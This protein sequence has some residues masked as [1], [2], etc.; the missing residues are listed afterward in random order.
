MGET[1]VISAL[2]SSIESTTVVLERSAVNYCLQQVEIIL[3]KETFYKEKA[4]YI[5]VLTLN[6][7]KRR[8]KWPSFQR[9]KNLYCSLSGN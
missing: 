3:I 6:R 2:K 4:Y 1:I 7:Y 8:E 9:T 5:Y